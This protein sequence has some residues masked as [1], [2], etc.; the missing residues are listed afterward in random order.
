[1]QAQEPLS[2]TCLPVQLHLLHDW[3]GGA[4]RWVADYCRA[5][6]N[7]RNL[8]LKP[9][10]SVSGVG[11]RVA[12]FADLADPRPISCWD[13]DRPILA[14]AVAHP[15]YRAILREIVDV[16]GVQAIAVSSLVV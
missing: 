16:Y 3:G 13:L 7:R 15:R 2:A 4:A 11:K 14:T 5:D 12:L 1:M 10:A 8:I 9:V 6:R